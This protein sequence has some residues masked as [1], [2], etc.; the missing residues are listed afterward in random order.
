MDPGLLPAVAAKMGRSGGRLVTIEEAMKAA[1]ES[2]LDVVFS[3]LPHL[4]SAEICAPFF[5]K[6]S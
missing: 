4:K 2:Q 3:A 6:R 5:G 1:G